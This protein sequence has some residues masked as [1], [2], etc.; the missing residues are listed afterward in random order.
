MVIA[1]KGS[2]FDCTIC[3]DAAPALDVVDFNKSCEE[4]NG[5]FLPLSGEPIYYCRCPSCGLCFAPEMAAWPVEK[6]A[7]KV[8]N[9][10]YVD[11][12]PD[13]C[14]ARPLGNAD[15]LARLFPDLV[16]HRHLD[17]GGGNGLLSETLCQIRWNT[18]S[19]DPFV[20]KYVDPTMIGSFDLISAFEV[21]EHV[22]DINLVLD[23]LA[24]MMREKAVLLFST[25][26][27]D[28]DIKP[29]SRLTW[30]YASPRNGHV[31][32]YSMESLAVLGRRHGFGFVSLSRGLHLFLRSTAPEWAR[33]LCRE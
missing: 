29:N 33:H 20:D 2:T 16:P 21:F 6:F 15:L 8:Y 4:Q 19:Y 30:W 3:G 5:T 23:Q 25:M 22:P 31:S 14:E 10:T 17:Y 9:D 11:I 1:A 7:E 27:S 13:Y 24:Y 32:L 26:T 12:D 28:G 18:M